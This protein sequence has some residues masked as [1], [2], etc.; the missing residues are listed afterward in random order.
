M[1]RIRPRG[2]K[3]HVDYI[4]G[5]DHIVRGALGTCNRVAAQILIHNLEIAMAEGPRSP[6]WPELSTVIPSRTFSRFAKFAGVRELEMPVW[7]QFRTQFENRQKEQI[8]SGELQPSTVA[9]YRGTLDEFDLFL[10]ECKVETLDRVNKSV[11]EDFRAWRFDRIRV[12]KNRSQAPSLNL[13]FAHLHHMFE[14]AIEQ[15]LIKKNPVVLK[16]KPGETLHG[17]A[18]PFTADE[19]VKLQCHAGQD[20]LLFLVLRW[21]GFRRSDAA[22]LIWQEV[23]LDQKKIERIAKKNRKKVILPILAELLTALEAECKRRNPVPGDPVLLTPNGVPYT[24]DRVYKRINRL[25]RR[26]GVYNVHPH[27]FRDTFAIDMLIRGADTS[28][29]AHMLGD[30]IQIVMKH[31]VPF[32]RELRERARWIANNGIGIE[33]FVTRASHQTDPPA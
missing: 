31:Y 9:R 6:L 17:G 7:K 33:Q 14:F 27:R 20:L 26:A 3:F 28:Y 4:K 19:L 25:G 5:R 8:I 13:E 16:G 2:K 32:V 1:L 23:D 15:E 11:I 30:T 29:V 10:Q 24:E 22:S 21:T 12:R 18:Q